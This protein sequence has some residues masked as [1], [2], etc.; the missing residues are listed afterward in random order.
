MS[1]SQTLKRNFH[2]VDQH[3][4]VE[5][6]IANLAAPLTVRRGAMPILEER[7]RHV[8]DGRQ[9][10]KDFT[11]IFSGVKTSGLNTD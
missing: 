3:A 8:S 6:I 1:H 9:R 2:V 11:R 4:T 5:I 10:I 7:R